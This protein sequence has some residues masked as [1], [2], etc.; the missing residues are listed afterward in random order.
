MNPWR[1]LR[2]FY[3]HWRAVGLEHHHD[4]QAM[5]SIRR[6]AELDDEWGLYPTF[7]T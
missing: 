5:V 4:E 1:S 3:H 6:L 2:I 7:R